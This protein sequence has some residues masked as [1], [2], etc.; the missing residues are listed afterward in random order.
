MPCF[1][2]DCDDVGEPR[3][4]VKENQM[5]LHQDIKAA[6]AEAAPKIAQAA[7]GSEAS[8]YNLRYA[9]ADLMTVLARDGAIVD[10]LA[11]KGVRVTIEA[12]EPAKYT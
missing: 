12:K 1:P 6:C 3:D 8:I 9:V 2:G 4:A 11:A 5:G 10:A 7:E